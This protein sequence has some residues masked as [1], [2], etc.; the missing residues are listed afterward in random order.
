MIAETR[1]AREHDCLRLL[2]ANK[3]YKYS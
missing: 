2:I 1:T 3:A